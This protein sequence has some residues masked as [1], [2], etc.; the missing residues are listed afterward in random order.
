[1]HLHLFVL[2]SEPVDGPNTK[3]SKA[4]ASS[5]IP[6]VQHAST[7]PN[8]L[9]L[10]AAAPSCCLKHDNLGSSGTSFTWPYT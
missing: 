10:E 1:M 4:W 6:V 9:H 7:G 3:S 5:Q 2:R 8:M